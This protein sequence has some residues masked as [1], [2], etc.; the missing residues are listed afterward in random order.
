MSSRQVQLAAGC[1]VASMAA[2]VWVLMVEIH[3]IGATASRTIGASATP[4]ARIRPADTTSDDLIGDALDHDPF[5]STR[6]RPASRYGAS[7]QVIALQPPAA[8]ETPHLVGTVVDAGGGSFVLCQLGT[9]TPHV[10]RI[11]QKLGTYQL[12]SISQGAAIFVTG[13]GQRLEL[14]VPKTG[15]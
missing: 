9:G 4:P 6:K 1:S 12:R 10:V 3:P 15:S 11:G 5:S 2:L 14:R 7:A 13:D 8:V